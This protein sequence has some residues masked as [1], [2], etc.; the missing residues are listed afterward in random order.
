M[1]NFSDENALKIDVA[2]SNCEIQW[3]KVMEWWIY[4]IAISM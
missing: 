1:K 3:D 4:L 2:I